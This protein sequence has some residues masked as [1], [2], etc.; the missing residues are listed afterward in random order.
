MEKNQHAVFQFLKKKESVFFESNKS[1]IAAE[2]PRFHGKIFY[3]MKKPG[4]LF[5]T[6]SNVTIFC[7]KIS[8]GTSK[9]FCCMADKSLIL[10][11]YSEYCEVKV[12]SL[13][14]GSVK[15]I[16]KGCLTKQQNLSRIWQNKRNFKN[17]FVEQ[18]KILKSGSFPFCPSFSHAR[19]NYAH[20]HALRETFY[21]H[22]FQNEWE[23]WTILH[24][25][26]SLILIL[27]RL[28]VKKTHFI[29]KKMT[30][31]QKNVELNSLK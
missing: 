24:K 9:S 8:F 25:K 10:K 12:N 11:W 14:H 7:S 22:F 4:L 28:F 20:F 31:P 30:C 21:S 13:L 23:I 1:K 3:L 5:T 29:D 27:L 17:T 15:T 2:L 6:E 19:L 16:S 18:I 26:V